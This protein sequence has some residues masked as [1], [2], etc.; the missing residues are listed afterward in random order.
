ME[1][2]KSLWHRIPWSEF[3]HGGAVF[4]VLLA[5]VGGIFLVAIGMPGT[6]LIALSGIVFSF[7]YPFDGGATSPWWVGGVLIALALFGELMEFVVGTLGS[8]PLK[9]SNG[10]IVCAF[11]GGIIGAIVGVPVFLIGAILGLFLG[12]FLGALVYEWWSLKNFGR[13]LVN[14]TAV[15]AT[16]VVATFLKATLALVMGLYLLIK[17][18]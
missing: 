2:L 3:A 17:V 16:R 11:I 10:A 1:Y 14:A 6:W 12:A 13:A 9:V 7:F 18:F 8:K 5:I 15:L 4:F